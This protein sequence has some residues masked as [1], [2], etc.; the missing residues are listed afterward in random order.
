MGDKAKG[1]Y[2]K[3][4]VRRTDGGSERGEKH[5]HCFHY[6]LDLAHDP[7]A[8]PALVAYAESCRADYPLLAAG[9]DALLLTQPFGKGGPEEIRHD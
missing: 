6:V 4:E 2:R 1:L 5:E 9:I 3:F 8:R 7:H